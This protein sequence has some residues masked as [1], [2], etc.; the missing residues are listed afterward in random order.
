MSTAN[1]QS[2]NLYSYVQNDPVNSVDPSGLMPMLCMPD[3]YY[4]DG[5]WVMTCEFWNPFGGFEPKPGGGAGGGGKDENP[6]VG[7]PDDVKGRDIYEECMKKIPPGVPVPS[8][9]QA[10][11]IA[12]AAREEGI[13]PMYL[14]VTASTESR[15]SFNLYPMNGPH[16]GGTADIGPGQLDYAGLQNWSGLAGLTNVFGTN[17]AVGQQFNGDPVSNLRAAARLIQDMGGGREGTIHYHSGKGSFLKKPAGQQALKART[18]EYNQR[19]PG[20][21]AFFDC[22]ATDPFGFY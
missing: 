22:L 4:G 9:D 14:A 3:R 12:R 19:A 10:R 20:Y 7:N 6:R 2:F 21:Q 5:V 18:R 15:P 17:L 11:A 1:P 16:G 13:H 8:R